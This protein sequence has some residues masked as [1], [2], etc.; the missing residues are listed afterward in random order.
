[1]AISGDLMVTPIDAYGVV[2]AI[3][4]N[5]GSPTGALYKP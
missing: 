3:S 4:H 5:G 2:W 1:M